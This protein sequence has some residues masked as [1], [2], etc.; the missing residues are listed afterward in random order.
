MHQKQAMRLRRRRGDPRRAGRS[1]AYCNGS[2]CGCSGVGGPIVAAAAMAPT[3]DAA[4]A[5][6]GTGRGGRS[7]G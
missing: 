6:L 7:A 3:G 2:G 5:A 1:D 4:P